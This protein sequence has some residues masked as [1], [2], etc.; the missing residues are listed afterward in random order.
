MICGAPFTT[1]APAKV[2]LIAP[3]VRAITTEPISSNG[4]RPTR[5]MNRIATN[6]VITLVTEVITVTTRLSV[7]LKPTACH[8][9]LE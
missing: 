7:V 8:S 4:L 3:R 6:V 1:A 2:Q 5:S 9:T